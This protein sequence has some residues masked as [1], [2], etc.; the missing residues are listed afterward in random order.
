MISQ[1]AQEALGEKS[2]SLD[3]FVWKTLHATQSFKTML[4]KVSVHTDQ[5]GILLKRRCCL[6]GP[7]RGQR[8]CDPAFVTGTRVTLCCWSV[9]H[10]LSNKAWEI[11]SA[12]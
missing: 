11:L 7:A 1:S 4:L 9:N 3:K 10:I 6:S 2:G 5:L 8:A 12:S